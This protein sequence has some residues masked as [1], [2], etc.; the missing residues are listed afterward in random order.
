MRLST[1]LE[2]FGGMM[3]LKR[4]QLT[5]KQL[6]PDKKGQYINYYSPVFAGNDSIIAIKTSLST[7]P[8]FVLI[9]PSERSEKKIHTPGQLYPFFISFGNGKLVW[10]ETQ[11][12]PR[13]NNRDYSV[14][15]LMDLKT[16]KI[17]RLSRKSRYLAASVSPNGRTI[18][19]IENTASNKNNLVILDAET[20]TVLRSLPAPGNVYLQHPQWSSEGDRLTV[21]YLTEGG[22]GIMSFNI[23]THQWITLVEAGPDDLQSS[24]LKNDSL[25]FISSRSGTDNIYL[26]SADH[27]ITDLTR[28]RFG[29][30]D[31]YFNGERVFFSDYSSDGNSICSIKLDNDPGSIKY[32][33]SSKSFLI[34]RFENKPQ[35][36]DN[37]PTTEY[38]SVPYR[39]WNHLFK[40]HSWMPFYADIEEIKSDPA[41]IRP[42]ASIMTQNHLSTL[43]STIGYEYSKDKNHVFH[44]R[45]T[46]KGWYPVIESHL[47]YGN[48]AQIFKAGEPIGDP[49]EIQAGLRFSNAV[50]IPLSFSSGNFSQFVRSSF[51]TDY[52]NNYIYDRE[53]GIYDYGQTLLS[54]RL[55]ISNYSRSA[56]VIYIQNWAQTID[57]NYLLLL[58]TVRSME[59]PLL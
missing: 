16:G 48:N 4:K 13:W 9:K 47:D 33:V 41:S 10:V 56:N 24:F 44:S 49:S 18:G 15:K 32:N 20:G 3:F 51:T 5:M 37:Y 6:N 8:S 31:L 57:L 7:P 40:F 54:G 35:L 19:A 52:R 12:D 42:G 14:I 36:T 21:I 34:N 46:W 53:E 23:I 38:K 29:V 43:T 50:S 27:K 45:V 22:E 58:S 17:T 39:K 26:Q 30:S 55:Y 11:P 2:L 59:Q 28:S 25:I 1:A